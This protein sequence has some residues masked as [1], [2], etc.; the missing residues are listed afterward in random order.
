MDVVVFTECPT[1]D[2]YRA[3]M[4]LHEQ[5]KIELQFRDSRSFY[6]V[7]LKIY[8]S[9]SFL[10]KIGHRF[11]SK[12]LQV[13]KKI[14]WEEI[15]SSVSAYFIL[16]FTSKKLVTLFAPYSSISLYL[17]FL[18]FM[19]KD[20]IFMTSWPYWNGKDAAYSG[21][22]LTRFFWRV[23]LKDIHAVTV[24][25]TARKGLL[26]YTSHVTQIP[27]AVD[28]RTFYP[29]EKKKHF[30]V[31][32][33]GRMIPEKGLKELL[34]VAASLP[35]ISFVFAGGGSFA[36]ELEKVHLKNVSYLGVVRD[37]KRL[38]Q[39]FRESHVFVLNSYKVL[40]WEELYGI[41]LLEAM[42]SGTAV[43]STD[44]VG[45]KEI[46]HTEFGI[47]IPQH[48]PQKLKDI[49][50]RCAKEEKLLEAMGRNGRK[51]AEAAYDVEKLS[52]LWYEVL[53]GKI[54]KS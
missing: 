26:A 51:F 43:I 20:L 16:P 2:Y 21:N 6:L 9:F 54:F 17:F 5:G 28:M 40:G 44:C 4:Y 14:T 45:P 49:L 41:V 29:G 1:E 8:S 33:V 37:R 18:K 46:V 22:V 35:E 32:Y 53:M 11:F 47:L 24:S 52:A 38:A 13:E 25:E 36:S 34:D 50:V 15:F 31:L 42:A 27:H 7:F 39:L 30:Q 12:P 48:S 10:R 19:K 23:F 3:L